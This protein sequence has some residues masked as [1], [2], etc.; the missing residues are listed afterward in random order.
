MQTIVKEW[1]TTIAYST[2]PWYADCLDKSRIGN[3][4]PVLQSISTGFWTT[5]TLSICINEGCVM[6]KVLILRAQIGNLFNKVM[7]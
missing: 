7:R 2:E 1:W 5:K 6:Q 3:T 4:Y